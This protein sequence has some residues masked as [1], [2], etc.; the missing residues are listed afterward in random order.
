MFDYIA[1]AIM[2]FCLIKDIDAHVDSEKVCTC[3]DFVLI[4]ELLVCVVR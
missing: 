2:F 1:N 3:E 4:L